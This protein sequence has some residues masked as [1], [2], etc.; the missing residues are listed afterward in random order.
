MKNRQRGY[1]WKRIAPLRIGFRQMSSQGTQGR[2]R[3]VE[4]E[5]HVVRD[6]TVHA[7]RYERCQ[8][9][10]LNELMENLNSLLT[11]MGWVVHGSSFRL[12]ASFWGTPRGAA[13]T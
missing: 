1:A 9:L 4:D 13:K 2:W 6:Q 5:W 8:S 12:P 10:L 11:K 7:E 3:R